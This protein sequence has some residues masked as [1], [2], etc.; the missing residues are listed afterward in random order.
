MSQRAYP[1]PQVRVGLVIAHLFGSLRPIYGQYCA[2][3]S[4]NSVYR[5]RQIEV[6]L[7]LSRGDFLKIVVLYSVSE[8]IC[9][10]DFYFRFFIKFHCFLAKF[11]VVVFRIPV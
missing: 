7:Y 10:K 2:S 1:Q 4:W 6:L 11:S 3:R 5:N 8:K 9:R